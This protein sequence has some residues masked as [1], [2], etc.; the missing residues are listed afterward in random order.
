MIHYLESIW[1]MG[2]ADG[3]ITKTPK[4]LHI[5]FAKQAYKAT[6]WHDFF[7]QMTVYLEQHK[8]IAKFDAYLHWAIPKYANNLQTQQGVYKD[9][10]AP[11]WQ[12]AQISPVP[13]I[14]I[15]IL[16][17]VYSIHNFEFYM[18]KFF[19]NYNIPLVFSPD[20]RLTVFPKAT[21][22][23][24]N[25]FATALVDCV[26][27]SPVP[28]VLGSPGAFDMVLIKKAEPGQGQFPGRLT[29]GMPA[30]CI[31]QVCLIF[32]LLPHYNIHN[33]LVY[34]QQFDR[35]S[36]RAPL[37][38]VNMYRVKQTCHTQQYDKCYVEEV[39]PLVLICQTCHLIPQFGRPKNT[40]LI[41]TPTADPLELFEN[42]FINS[43][44]DLHT[45][46]MLSV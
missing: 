33:P 16:S 6:N 24:D 39:I 5:E 25:A 15:S 18:N 28:S 4:R 35:P 2:A 41:D 11:G 29:Y 26:H 46:Q 30:H 9:P 31:G 37:V 38:E 32:K 43:Y 34:I 17:Q 10:A 22:I 27:A 44:F 8:H 1:Q 12:L 7:A 45:F 20:N 3:Y 36:W 23:I 14:P 21:Q 19:D 13:P 42:F 40:P